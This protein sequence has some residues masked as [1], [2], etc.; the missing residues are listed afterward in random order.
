MSARRV[1]LCAVIYGVSFVVRSVS[2]FVFVRDGVSFAARLIVDLSIMDLLEIVPSLAVLMVM[3]QAIMERRQDHRNESLLPA[4]HSGST[5]SAPRWSSTA[6][7]R[8]ASFWEAPPI[9]NMAVHEISS[10]QT[11]VNYQGL[12]RH[13]PVTQS[14][15][16]SL[17]NE[18]EPEQM[19][20]S[21]SPASTFITAQSP[22]SSRPTSMSSSPSTATV[23]SRTS[24]PTSEQLYDIAIQ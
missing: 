23:A 17:L 6:S 11:L 10:D 22:A 12:D 14:T 18:G 13:Q 24:R 16:A 8:S 7:P 2:S 21:A 9:E 19:P 5:L 1:G 20:T 4:D 3:R 15:P